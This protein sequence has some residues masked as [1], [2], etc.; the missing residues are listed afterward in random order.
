MCFLLQLLRQ[1]M[2]SE[3]A[4]LRSLEKLQGERAL[5]QERLR[6]LQRAVAQLESEKR[7]A[8]RAAVRLEKDKAALHNTLDKVGTLSEQAD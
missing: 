6:S 3:E 2:E 4:A 1:R 8:E 7:E 5:A